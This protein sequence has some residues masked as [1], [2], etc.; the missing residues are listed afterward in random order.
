VNA[1]YDFSAASL[2]AAGLSTAQAKPTSEGTIAVASG[3]GA[4][5]KVLVQTGK[6]LKIVDAT[7]GGLNI[8][9]GSSETGVLSITVDAAC[10]LKFSG[11]GSTGDSSWP[12]TTNLNSFSVDSTQVF[13]RTSASDKTFTNATFTCPAAGTYTIKASGITF[14]SLSCE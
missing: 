10:T 11:K 4:V 7:S 1:S 8:A 2:T 5:L 6:N 14:T 13:T 3:S 9:A 12:T